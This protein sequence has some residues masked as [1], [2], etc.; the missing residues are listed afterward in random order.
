MARSLFFLVAAAS[1]LQ[2]GE[3]GQPAQPLQPQALL[4]SL[5]KGLAASG[6]PSLTPQNAAAPSAAVPASGAAPA[7]AGAMGLPDPSALLSL[8]SQPMAGAAG[9]AQT[10]PQNPLAALGAGGAPGQNPLAALLGAAS[11]GAGAGAGGAPGGLPFSPQQAMQMMQ[12][13]GGAGMPPEVAE[14]AQTLGAAVSG[15]RDMV[16]SV[17][18]AEQYFKPQQLVQDAIHAVQEL[19]EPV[20]AQV[21]DKA[22][23]LLAEVPSELTDFL[24]TQMGTLIERLPGHMKGTFE[25]R[26]DYLLEH[27]SELVA[28]L[29]DAERV[30]SETMKHALAKPDALLAGITKLIDS[31]PPEFTATV[32]QVQAKMLGQAEQV[33]QHLPQGLLAAINEAAPGAIPPSQRPLE[34]QAEQSRSNIFLGA[35]PSVAVGAQ[36]GATQPV[37]PQPP[38]FLPG[39]F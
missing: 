3:P 12:A 11:A 33:V 4:D 8:L 14:L 5:L 1:G 19:P 32:K 37:P 6:A 15:A 21:R 20:K 23:D 2:P 22:H 39:M 35:Q 18:A 26:P 31:M 10:A 29:T 38:S 28:N 9:A 24:K 17:Q 13:M 16:D 34:S 27:G 7:A 36:G 30:V 25:Q